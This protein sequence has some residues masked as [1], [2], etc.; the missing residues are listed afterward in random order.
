MTRSNLLALVSFA[1]VFAAGL[2][3]GQRGWLGGGGGGTSN[4]SWLAGHLDLSQK[5][6]EE[7]RQIWMKQLSATTIDSSKLWLQFEERRDERVRALLTTPEQRAAY[8]EIVADHRKA[9]AEFRSHLADSHRAA[10]EAT[11]KIL[12]PQQRERFEKLVEDRSRGQASAGFRPLGV[13]VG[14]VR[15]A[16]TAP[17]DAQDR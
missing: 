11:K 5:Q 13:P 14:D 1:A 9:A 12:N 7:V 16:A 15:P 6:R 2:F 8:E 10:E 3:V 17:K 4:D